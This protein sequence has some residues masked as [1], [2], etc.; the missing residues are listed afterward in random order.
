MAKHDEKGGDGIY[1]MVGRGQMAESAV[2]LRDTYAIKPNAPFYH[3]TFGLW[4][5]IDEWYK[6]GLDR[7][8]DLNE[9]FMLDE[10]GFHP[11]GGLGW[12]EAE[13]EPKYK[14]KV[15]EDRGDHELVQDFAGRT[16]L[17]FK[18]R[19]QGFMPE[20]VDHPVK[21]MKSWEENVKWRLDPNSEQRYKGLDE[22]MKVAKAKAAEGLM[23]QQMIIGGYMFL[24][25][26]MGPA[27]IMYVFY[28]R[29]ELVHDCME[30]WLEL[31]D[32]V[33][34]RYQEHITFDEI[35]IAEDICYNHGLLISPDMVKEFLFP[36]YQQLI[37]NMKSR[38]LDKSRK[39]YIQVDTDGDL[40]P[41]ID[42]YKEGI[43]VDMLDPFEAA[44]GCDVVEIGK[45]YPWLIMSG[46][47]D[48]RVLSEDIETIDK[49]LDSILPVM[50]ARG[51][52]VP[53]CDHGVPPEVPW[54][55]YLHYRKRCV[56]IGG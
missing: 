47:I 27:D 49:Y 39:L 28:D 2:K 24:R 56:E 21:D 48:K 6:Q 10:A 1:S 54:Q 14:E 50:R 44:S 51:G 45:E 19:R 5:C 42:L 20:Y 9:L 8:A 11:I 29:P 34:R 55:N 43:G 35:Y 40:R 37:N 12:C 17:Y 13:F 3:K 53:T 41:A 22:Q 15:L 31:S 4:M 32:A 30:T 46:G 7:N 33:I 16:V 52:F 36:Y 23:I 26:L 18:G 38:Q 25:S